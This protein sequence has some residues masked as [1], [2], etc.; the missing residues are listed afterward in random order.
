MPFKVELAIEI[1]FVIHCELRKSEGGKT[2]K[3]LERANKR[4]G[5][6]FYWKRDAG[7][8]KGRFRRDLFENQMNQSPD[9]EDARAA[10]RSAHQG[11]HGSMLLCVLHEPTPA[12]RR[13]DRYECHSPLH[14][15]RRWVLL[16]GRGASLSRWRVQYSPASET[17]LLFRD[18]CPNSFDADVV[19]GCC[20]IF[21]KSLAVTY[22][23]LIRQMVSIARD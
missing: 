22:A 5:E 17:F 21:A 20:V 19:L 2:W 23:A 8:N 15:G 6:T 1:S 10:K 7:K 3:R 9:K 16:G 14:R 4:C 12:A 18:R 13:G 11:V